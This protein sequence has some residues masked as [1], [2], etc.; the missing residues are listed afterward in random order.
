MKQL[1][2]LS[3]V[4][5]LLLSACNRQ[6]D[7]NTANNTQQTTNPKPNMASNP[8]EA[9]LI[10]W[11]GIEELEAKMKQ[12]P[13]KVV[14]DLYTDWCGWCKRMDKATFQHPDVAD[15]INK[16][17]YAVKFNA[18]NPNTIS[19]N[20]KQWEF[21]QNGRRGTNR[22]AATLILGENATGRIGYPTI[23]F[24]DENLQRINAFPGYKTPDKFEA[25]MKYIAQNEYKKQSLE[26]F[27]RTFTPTIPPQATGSANIPQRNDI[28]LP[29][30][31]LR[32][33]S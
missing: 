7:N 29:V 1:I 9:S 28:T 4:F 16:N 23:A 8:A 14:V 3:A 20:G 22:L 18:E 24:M 26:Q 13:R 17:F 11:I 33:K 19:F 27:M 30:N 21:M 6:E 5:I 25:L 15:Y 32:S 31:K 2:T 12:E 10:N